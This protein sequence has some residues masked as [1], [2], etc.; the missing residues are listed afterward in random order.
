MSN[1]YIYRIV[2]SRPEMLTE[3]PTADEGRLAGEH[4][5]YLQQL[6]STGVCLIAG[7]T[8]NSDASTFGIVIFSASSEESARE[9][10]SNDPAVKYGVFLGEVFPFSIATG[11]LAPSTTPQSTTDE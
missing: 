4:F 7:R 8:Q 10:M 1:Q 3:G 9:I 5:Q 11:C 2:P 6:T